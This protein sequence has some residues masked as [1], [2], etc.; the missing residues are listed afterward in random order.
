MNQAKLFRLL[1]LGLPIGIVLTA[2][3]SLLYHF[4][5]KGGAAAE[6]EEESRK[7]ALNFRRKPASEEAVQLYV[8]RLGQDI[9]P[10][11]EGNA[12][13]H[14]QYRSFL[15]GLLGENNFGYKQ[16]RQ[17]MVGNGQP[18]H[19][20]VVEAEITGKRR[21]HEVVLLTT[22]C[23]TEQ[24]SAGALEN[25]SGMA[26]LLCLAQAWVGTQPE[27]TLRMSFLPEA[28]GGEAHG[29]AWLVKDL[30]TGEA[31]QT[32]MSKV[33]AH[34]H[35]GRLGGYA[36]TTKPTEGQ[37]ALSMTPQPVPTAG[38]PP[39]ADWRAFLEANAAPKAVLQPTQPA[40]NPKC[41][42]VFREAALPT[43]YLTDGPNALPTPTALDL[44]AT[45]NTAI[46]LEMTRGIQR[47]VEPLLSP[48]TSKQP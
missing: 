41:L 17:T 40:T 42:T 1:L 6:T 45:V 28:V 36:A 23:G 19:L 11:G 25:G 12:A 3:A 48:S 43:V 32:N 13:A 7:N 31:V 20:V 46:T 22:H 30:Q 27:R 47:L 5:S 39:L 21:P 18:E 15:T 24:L 44:P 16:L 9:G 35:I 2:S 4:S 10:R 37:L 34:F 38:M 29:A 14:R 33:I 8:R 26:A